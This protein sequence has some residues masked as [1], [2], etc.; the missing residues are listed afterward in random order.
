[1][2]KILI[3]ED[4]ILIAELERDYLTMADCDVRIETNGRNGLELALDEK[5]DLI[6]LDVMMPEMNGFEVCKRIREKN[7]VPIILVTARQE[8]ADIIK[9]MGL[10]ADDYITKPFSPAQ[11]TARV[12]AHI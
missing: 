7:T 8:D 1:M 6:L 11:L 5:W 10:G 3:I 9:G 4:D 12:K 2:K